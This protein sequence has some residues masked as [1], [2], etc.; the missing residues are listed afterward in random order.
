M[1]EQDY[2]ICLVSAT[3]KQS[4]KILAQV[5]KLIEDTPWLR[6]LAPADRSYTWSKTQLNTTNG[7]MMYVWS[8]GPSARGL[9]PNEII[10]DDIQREE[11]ISMEQIKDTFHTVFLGRGQTKQCKHTVV[12]T[13]VKID[14]LL[15]DLK[16]K[17]EEGG[18][19]AFITYPAVLE[20]SKGKRKPLWPER[21]TLE[22]L[23]A[24]K[25]NM[26]Q[27]RF[28]QEYLCKPS[29]GGEGFFRKDFI[30]SSC[31]D[32]LGFSYQ[33]KGIVTIGADFAMSDAPTGD[34]NVFTVVD[35]YKGEYVK[36]ARLG[37]EV[38]DVKVKD[39]VVIKKIDRY[40]GSVGQIARIEQLVKEYKPTK[41]IVDMSSFGHRF[42]Q[43]LMEKGMAVD[44][45]DFWRANRNHL[46]L[47]LRRLMETEDPISSPGRLVIPTSEKDGTFEV[48]KTLISELDGFS[49]KMTPSGMK[50]IA[51]NLSHDDMTMSLALAVKDIIYAQPVPRHFFLSAKP[52]DT[53]NI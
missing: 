42:A 46:L 9:Q 35:S 39:P 25:V 52:K 38:F 6:H 18:I 13:P 40:R 22:E 31:D 24:I 28:S 26:G 29:H 34:Y 17:S 51:S 4:M 33:T 7:N 10:Y 48:T 23:D 3:L 53:I 37:K 32:N 16:K 20:D 19:W 5:Q 11:N 45:Q 36:K 1:K 21:F 30:V 27:Y 15:Y 49:E 2:E 43:E 8:F 47:N 14:D 50:T 41:V 44:E 12:G